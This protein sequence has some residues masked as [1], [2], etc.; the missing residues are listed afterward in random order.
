ME[1]GVDLQHCWLQLGPSIPPQHSLE[2]AG[3]AAGWLV[4]SPGATIPH[5]SV[6][7]A[8]QPPPSSPC[9][10]TSVSRAAR[11]SRGPAGFVTPRLH[12]KPLPRAGSGPRAEGWWHLSPGTLVGQSLQRFGPQGPQGVPRSPISTRG[13]W[14]LRAV[15]AAPRGLVL[16]SW[17]S[18]PSS[19]LRFWEKIGAKKPHGKET[20]QGKKNKKIKNQEKSREINNV[21][22]QTRGR[23]NYRRYQPPPLRAGAAS[24][25]V[26]GG[27]ARD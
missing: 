14:H 12:S 1:L 21:P 15:L 20:R 23:G 11:R 26:G 24:P 16:G 5:L 4:P 7:S 19:P 17:C 18:A 9:P 27:A 8:P 3:A 13:H 25:G 22:S 10:L 2:P 6:S